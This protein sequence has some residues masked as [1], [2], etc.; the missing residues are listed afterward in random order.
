MS[1]A[2]NRSVE[3]AVSDRSLT[4]AARAD[5]R[6]NALRGW[7]LRVRVLAA[8]ELLNLFAESHAAP[9]VPAHGAVVRIDRKVLIMQSAG[10]LAVERQ[11]QM[12]FPVQGGPSAREFVVP[13][14]GAGELAGHVGGV[15][16]DL[17][18]H[19]ALLDVLA[20]GQAQ[21]LLGRDVAQ[22]GGP[23]ESGGRAR[24]V[25]LG[26]LEPGARGTVHR[27]TGEDSFLSGSERV[28]KLASY[29]RAYGEKG[30]TALQVN[31]ID[32]ETLKLAQQKPDEYKNLL[33]RVTG[34][35]AYFVMLGKEI[36]DEIIARESHEL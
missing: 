18:G 10:G 2:V 20:G 35:N 32:P 3:S 21:V 22:E 15:G 24:V 23:V 9:V 13:V 1:S 4:L 25:R 5:V 36:Q 33:V 31:V 12:L 30:G 6:G 7:R 34:Y 11:G 17:V 8:G 14:A 29:L 28:D 26:E 27:L 16:G 19:A